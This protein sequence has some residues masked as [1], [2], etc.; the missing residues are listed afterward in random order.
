[1]K[2]EKKKKHN[3]VNNLIIKQPKKKNQRIKDKH[4]VDSNQSA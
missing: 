2:R 3:K 4:Q 1:M